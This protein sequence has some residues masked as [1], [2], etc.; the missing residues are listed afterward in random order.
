MP[1]YQFLAIEAFAA[2]CEPAIECWILTGT[3]AAQYLRTQGV[4]RPKASA[5]LSS[6]EILASAAAASAI[7]I[8][9]VPISWNHH[10]SRSPVRVTMGTQMEVHATAIAE[11]WPVL[12]ADGARV[13]FTPAL[14]PTDAELRSGV[15][16]LVADVRTGVAQTYVRIVFDPRTGLLT[17]KNCFWDF[18]CLPS[19]R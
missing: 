13:A 7:N 3:G 18:R 5:W 19:P 17:D 2:R 16:L 10:V 8:W 14:Y 4:R 12:S 6:N 1:C 9:R 15:P 11:F